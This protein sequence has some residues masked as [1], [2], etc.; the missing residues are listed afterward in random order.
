MQIGTVSYGLNGDLESAD[1]K[2]N[3][4]QKTLEPSIESK[5]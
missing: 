5:I 4:N 1:S 3:P 2:E